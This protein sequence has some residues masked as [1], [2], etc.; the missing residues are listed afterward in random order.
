[1]TPAVHVDP[2]KGFADSMETGKEHVVDSAVHVRAYLPSENV[3]ALYL[4]T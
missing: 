4:G 3:R 2:V 1:M